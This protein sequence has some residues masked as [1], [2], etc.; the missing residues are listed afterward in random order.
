LHLHLAPLWAAL[1]RVLPTL[2]GR[3]L[4]VGCGCKPYRALFHPSVTA[5]LGVDQRGVHPSPDL[6]ADAH[7]LPFADGAF[8]AVVSFQVFEHL[9]APARALGECT[10]VLRPGGDLVVTVP[11]VWPAHEIPHDY[12]RFTRY[13]LESLARD[14]GLTI[15]EL[16]P[17]GALWSTLGQMACLELNRFL[18]GRALVPLINLGARALDG[19]AREHLTLNWLLHARHP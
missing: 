10:R 1:A 3:V 19:T 18:L 5:Y 9:A 16:T 12:W 13:G 4:D 6:I 2:R 7:A 8:D 14:A 15:V 11:G 17:L